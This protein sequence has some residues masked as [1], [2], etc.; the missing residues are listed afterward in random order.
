MGGFDING[1]KNAFF[2]EMRRAANLDSVDGNI[3]TELEKTEAKVIHSTFKAELANITA[4][5]GDAF[6]KSTDNQQWKFDNVT[7]EE[8]TSLLYDPDLNI[9]RVNQLIQE[10]PVQTLT[11]INKIGESKQPRETEEMAKISDAD[12]EGVK[13]YTDLAIASGRAE[14]ISKNTKVSE[15]GIDTLGSP[16]FDAFMEAVYEIFSSEKV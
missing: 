13:A 16:I 12:T 1:F 2:N 9:A 3:N 5:I 11:N 10:K 7:V 6:V 14:K 8:L 4:P 15:E